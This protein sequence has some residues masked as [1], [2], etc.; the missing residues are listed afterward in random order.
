MVQPTRDYRHGYAKKQPYQRKSQQPEAVE[1]VDNLSHSVKWIWVSLVLSG[2]LLTVFFVVD[3]FATQ[4][5]KSSSATLAKEITSHDTP[6]KMAKPKP[7]IVESVSVDKKTT[8]AKLDYTFYTELAETEVVVDVEPISLKLAVPYYIL[9][10]T[11]V[12]ES[13]ALK[14]Q[15]RLAGY[16]QTLSL[17]ELHKNQ[18]IYYRLKLGPFEDRLEMNKKRNELRRLGVDTLLIKTK[19]IS[20]EAKTS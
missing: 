18:R 16:G 11:F 13:H 1:S 12:E 17:S 14:E 4:G 10:G 3:H 6:D 8:P 9:A 15:A 2:V 20:K 5:V 7:L 19:P